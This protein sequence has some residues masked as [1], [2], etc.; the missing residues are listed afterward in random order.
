M[1]SPAAAGLPDARD[2]AL[3]CRPTIACTAD[4]VPPGSFEV[5]G[6]VLYRR[7][8]TQARQ[9][10]FPLL[11][12][13]TFTEALQLQ[14]GTNGYSITRGQVPAQYLDDVTI[15]PKLH[16][17]DQSE[18]MPA[19]AVSAQ[20]SIPTFRR[21]GYLQT[22]DALFTGYVTKDLGPIHADLNAGMNLWRIED[23]PLP[24]GFAALACSMNLIAPFG[25]MVE[26]YAF[27]NAAP[28]TARDGGLLFALSQTP[29][30]WLVLD[31]GADWGLFPSTRAFSLFVGF[32]VIPAVLWRAQS[33][34]P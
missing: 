12:K 5:E 33:R 28:V 27:S 21:R 34:G 7:I 14:V 16:L 20:A 4:I 2:H 10:T 11:L 31:E 24:Q 6:G 32:T 13:Q 8:D 3:P 17:A 23:H 19:L 15:G 26:G 29:R 25:A 9:W 18:R 22:Y 1:E 30:P